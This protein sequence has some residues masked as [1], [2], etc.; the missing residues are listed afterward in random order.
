M[1]YIININMI[2]LMTNESSIAK[3]IDKRLG[4]KFKHSDTPHCDVVIDVH[5]TTS[6]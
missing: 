3:S 6:D 1:T 4:P 5:N 2:Y